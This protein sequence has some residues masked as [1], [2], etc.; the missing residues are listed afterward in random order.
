MKIL[1]NSESF[2]PGVYERELRKHRQEV[3]NLGAFIMHS[4]QEGQDAS[5]VIDL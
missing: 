3:G 2:T 1:D 4:S 5:A